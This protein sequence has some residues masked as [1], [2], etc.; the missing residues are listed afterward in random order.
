MTVIYLKFDFFCNF[1]RK[2]SIKSTKNCL[3]RDQRVWFSRNR[4][5]TCPNSKILFLAAILI[6][7]E[8]AVGHIGRSYRPILLIF[9][10]KQRK[11][12]LYLV[13]SFE[14][15]QS[16]I[17]TVRVPHRKSTKLLPWR[18]RFRNFKIREKIHW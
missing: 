9:N 7:F 12:T 10:S 8:N 5:L 17:A 11:T 4:H 2:M 16:K 14:E 13:L 3:F 6:F 1:S 18:H 15:N